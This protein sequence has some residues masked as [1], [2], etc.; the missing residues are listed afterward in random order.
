MKHRC[1]GCDE[2]IEAQDPMYCAPDYDL[3][4]KQLHEAERAL[5]DLYAWADGFLHPTTGMGAGMHQEMWP[6]LSLNAAKELARRT[7]KWRIR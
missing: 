4:I 5:N 1:I 3:A 7:E 2:I 6:G